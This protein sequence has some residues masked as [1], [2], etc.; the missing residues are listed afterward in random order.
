M[1]LSNDE[2]PFRPYRRTHAD[3]ARRLAAIQETN[4]EQSQR[5]R[6]RSKAPLGRA[7]LLGGTFNAFITSHGPRHVKRSRQLLQERQGDR[8]EGH[9]QEP[10][11]D[12]RRGEPV[13]PQGLEPGREASRHR[14]R[15]PDGRGEGAECQPLRHEDG[16]AGLRRPVRST[17]PSGARARASLATP[18]SPDVYAE[19]FSA[20]VDFLGTR[21]FVDRERIGAIGICGS[22]SFVISAAKIDPRS[23]GHR[24]GQHVRHGGRQPARAQE[25]ADARAAEEGPRRGGGAARRRVRGRRDQVHER[26]RARADRRAPTPSSGSSTTSTARPAA[27]SRR[28]AA[29]PN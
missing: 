13:P 16:R 2:G 22:G 7:C 26:D 5:L 23:E 8:R 3:W 24:D 21:P 27:S 12:E 9:L 10:V 20:A 14:R 28:R 15:A 1:R 4:H 29:R 6:H 19:S 18:S 17:C 25:V 11:P